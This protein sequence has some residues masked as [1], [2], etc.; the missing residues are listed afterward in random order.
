MTKEEA[1]E[2]SRYAELHS[3]T[4]ALPGRQ[5]VHS[6]TFKM[7]PPSRQPNVEERLINGFGS[8]TMAVWLVVP[9]EDVRP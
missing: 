5:V 4:Q 7:R 8:A 6:Q 9:P 1:L 3:T 2:F